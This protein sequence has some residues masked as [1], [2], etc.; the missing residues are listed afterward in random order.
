MTIEE[1]IVGFLK[2]TPEVTALVGG[3]TQFR[4]YPEVAPQEDK[5]T[6]VGTYPHGTY[7]VI[8]FPQLYHLD[9]PSKMA[10]PRIQVDWWGIGGKGRKEVTQL[11][12]ATRNASGGNPSGRKLDGFAGQWGELL[13][14]KCE[15]EDREFS[16]EPPVNAGELPFRRGRM[17]FVV[18]F[19]EDS[20]LDV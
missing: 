12:E 5:A 20:P 8:D 14:H 7:Q 3:G 10:H 18:W 11:V 1:F 16:T 17:D 2:A 13:I 9:G 6:G 19:K 4:F 15:L